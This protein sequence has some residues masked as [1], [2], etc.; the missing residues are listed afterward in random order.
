MATAGEKEAKEAARDAARAAV[1]TGQSRLQTEV[2]NAAK[3]FS[4]RRLRSAGDMTRYRIGGFLDDP[5]GPNAGA[6][7]TPRPR[8]TTTPSTTSAPKPPT[9]IRATPKPIAVTTVGKAA[10]TAGTTQRVG[11]GIVA[12]NKANAAKAAATQAAVVKTQ[13]TRANAQ[14]AARNKAAAKK[15]ATQKKVVKTQTTR[16]NAQHKARNKRATK[17]S[18]GRITQ[19]AAE[20]K[21]YRDRY[22]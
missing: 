18:G 14:H 20:N 4:S 1:V 7:T 8:P 5:M 19:R 15:A 22:I 13:T 21:A 3:A 12:T 9:A 11:V 10:S 6:S 16:A 2:G 17:P